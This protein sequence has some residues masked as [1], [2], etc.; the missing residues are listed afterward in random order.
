MNLQRKECHSSMDG[1]TDVYNSCGGIF[2]VIVL[3]D[4]IKCLFIYVQN[5]FKGNFTVMIF[6]Q[7]V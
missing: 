6:D 7:V 3:F 5:V 1:L 4:E 2:T